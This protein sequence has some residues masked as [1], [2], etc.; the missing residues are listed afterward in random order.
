MLG[1]IGKTWKIHEHRMVPME[2]GEQVTNVQKIVREQIA[3]AIENDL[4]HGETVMK[5]AFEQMNNESDLRACHTEMREI[6]AW[7]RRES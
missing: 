7:L 4:R 3:D 6:I 5:E 2:P 1:G